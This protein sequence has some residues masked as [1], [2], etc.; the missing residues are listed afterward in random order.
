VRLFPDL[1]F[2]SPVAT[3]ESYFL[4]TESRAGNPAGVAGIAELGVLPKHEVPQRTHSETLFAD[5]LV[6]RSITKSTLAGGVDNR[7]FASGAG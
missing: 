6:M 1:R 3:E 5:S 2:A 7:Y 4:N